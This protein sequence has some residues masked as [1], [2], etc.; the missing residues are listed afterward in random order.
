M[1]GSLCNCHFAVQQRLAPHCKSTI[2]Q[3]KIKKTKPT[4][5]RTYSES[6]PALGNLSGVMSESAQRPEGG[7]EKMGIGKTGPEL[8]GSQI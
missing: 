1:T 7:N 5:N 2:P 8:P 4:P 3:L 6:F